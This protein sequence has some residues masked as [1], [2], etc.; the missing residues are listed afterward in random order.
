MADENIITTPVD[1]ESKLTEYEA[2][3]GDIG[4]AVDAAIDRVLKECPVCPARDEALRL[5]ASARLMVQ[6]AVITGGA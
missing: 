3:M 4:V 2:K 1:Y 6:L 5:M